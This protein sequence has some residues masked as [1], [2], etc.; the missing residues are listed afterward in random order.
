MRQST[1]KKVLKKKL[2]IVFFWY[3][4][5]NFMFYIFNCDVIIL[6]YCNILILRIGFMFV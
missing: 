2:L 5:Y 4:N 1:R 3:S 6:F